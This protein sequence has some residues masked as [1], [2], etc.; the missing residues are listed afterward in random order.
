[1]KSDIIKQIEEL[2]NTLTN[3]KSELETRLA[4]INQV[5]SSFDNLGSVAPVKSKRGRKPGTKNAEPTEG[6]T[7]TKRGRRARNEMGLKEAAL[8]VTA[9]GALSKEEALEAI[10]KLGYVFAAKNPMNSLNTVLYNKNLFKNLGGKFIPKK[11]VR[12]KK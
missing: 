6:K 2:K 3:E 8:R 1:M 7:T 9:A 4:E 12:S 11:Q 5:L 10:Q